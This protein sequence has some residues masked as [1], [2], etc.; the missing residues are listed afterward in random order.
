MNRLLAY[1]FGVAV[2]LSMALG[3]AGQVRAGTPD[4]SRGDDPML[5][6]PVY[7]VQG[8]LGGPGYVP[9]PPPPSVRAPVTQP[10]AALV[11]QPQAGPVDTTAVANPFNATVALATAQ[12]RDGWFSFSRTEEGTCAGHQGVMVWVVRPPTTPEQVLA[13]RQAS[14]CLN[15]GTPCFPTAAQFPSSR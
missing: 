5:Q 1:A 10:P 4:D 11:T 9:S 13:S 14:A 2:L 8:P 3:P 15:A 6:A 12:C 7:A